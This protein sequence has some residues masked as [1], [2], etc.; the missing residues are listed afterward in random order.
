M[1]GGVLAE[2]G[3]TRMTRIVATAL[4]EGEGWNVIVEK[5]AGLVFAQ[6]KPKLA[7]YTHIALL[8]SERIPPPTIDDIVAETRTAYSGH[9]RAMRI[10]ALN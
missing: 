3:T 7:A 2:Y 10:L 1:S 9:G 4:S 5:E 6:T 8:G